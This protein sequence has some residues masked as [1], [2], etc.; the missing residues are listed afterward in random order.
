MSRFLILSTTICIIS[1]FN[2]IECESNWI[3]ISFKIL[4]F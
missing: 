2:W 1:R 3:W 4:K